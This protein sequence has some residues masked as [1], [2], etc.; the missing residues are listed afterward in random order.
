[1]SARTIAMAA[2]LAVLAIPPAFAEEFNPVIGKSGDIT[3]RET[4][5]DRLVA[6]QPPEVRK[7]LEE[8]PELKV[9]VVRD[10]LL[11]TAIAQKARKAGFDRKPEVKELLGYAVNEFLA[12]EYLA[13]EVV[14][15]LTVPEEELEKYYK[16]HEK[17]YIVPASVKA[18]HI[19][20]KL[21]GS[22]T[23][24][25]R[26]KATARAEE[27]LGRLKKGEDFAK[28]AAEVSEDTDTAN[29]GGELGTIAPGQT[30][31]KEFEEA[32]LSLK[33]GELSPV[34]A[35]PYG[36]HIIRVDERSEQRTATFAETKQY[37][38][39]RLLKELE[40]KKV[41]EFVEKTARESGLEVY[42][43]KITGVKGEETKKP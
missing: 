1:M 43:E 42:G 20:I 18:R 5:L 15:G 32:A 28:L 26:A 41:Q 11:K 31:S 29:K 13:R 8:K 38:T 40:G 6:L 34:V 10:L 39:A 22:A 9:E 30:N 3:L 33:A 16:E 27:I 25:E 24:D 35:T 36:L 7:Q 17:E 23:A 21:D 12:R 4:D 37:I 14:A 2:L 19:F